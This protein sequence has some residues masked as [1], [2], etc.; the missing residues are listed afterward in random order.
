MKEIFPSEILENTN[1][2]YQVRNQTKNSLVYILVLLV[3]SIAILLSF[4][5]KVPIHISSNGLIKT[6]IEKT[7]FISSAT[8]KVISNRIYNNKNVTKGDTLLVLDSQILNERYSFNKQRIKKITQYIDDITYLIA[9]KKPKEDS[10]KTAKYKVDFQQYKDNRL[11]QQKI[12][13]KNAKDY[14]REK[15][16]YSKGVTT[17]VH[18]EEVAFTYN[19]SRLEIGNIK[20]KK[21][22]QWQT[23]LV[24][25]EEGLRELKSTC[26][27]LSKEKSAYTIIASMTGTLVNCEPLQELHFVTEGEKLGEISPNGNLIV[28]CLVPSSS[29]GFLRLDQPAN[30]LID[31]YNYNQWGMASGQITEISNDVIATD[32]ATYFKI[33]CS[34]NESCLKLKN[35]IKGQIKKGMTLNSRF[36]LTERTISQLLFDQIDDWM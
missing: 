28:E 19:S 35:G 13:S 29:I 25:Y 4:I 14:S 21:L 18:L 7:N 31:T 34:L 16:L 11:T 15:K 10:I 36:K 24:A 20:N 22:N 1:D 27:Q 6:G 32:K 17:R 26:A 23:E 5:I 3:I 12:S 9:T 33:K 8:G 30:F 2:V